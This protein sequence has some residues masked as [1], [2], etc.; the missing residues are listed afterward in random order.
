[1]NGSAT[2]AAAIQ[3]LAGEDRSAAPGRAPPL[4]TPARTVAITSAVPRAGKT[5][6]AVNLAIALARMGRRVLLLDGDPG[7]DSTELLGGE[8]WV[9]RAGLASVLAGRATLQEPSSRPR[10]A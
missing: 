8:P 3:R 6:L 7:L 10:R 2:A 9:G 5:T 1:M 4:A